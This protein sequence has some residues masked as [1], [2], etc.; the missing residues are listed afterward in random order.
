MD[1]LKVLD[2]IQKESLRIST[3]VFSR[4]DNQRMRKAVMN[5]GANGFVYKSQSLLDFEKAIRM[6]LKGQKYSMPAKQKETESGLDSTS[7]QSFLDPLMER[8]SLTK[9]ETQ[10]LRLIAES[11]SNKEIASHL[12]ISEQTVGVH[13][14]DLMRKLGATN[15]ASLVRAAYEFQFLE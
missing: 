3:I 8:C 9:R 14:K 13:R 15:K 11:N 6:V 10:I 5:R 2:Y 4:Y 12:F 1:G 7:Q